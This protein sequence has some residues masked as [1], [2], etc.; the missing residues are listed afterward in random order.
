M[1]MSKESRNRRRNVSWVGVPFQMVAIISAGY[2]GGS[3]MDSRFQID[4]KWWTVGLT[5]FAVLLSLYQFLRGI[6][7][8][9]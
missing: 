6:K 8:G 9:E 1:K 2:W 3:L 4:N 7:R 5:L